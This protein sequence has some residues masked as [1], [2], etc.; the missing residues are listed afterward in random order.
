VG[1]SNFGEIDEAM[2]GIRA[3]TALLLATLALVAPAAAQTL[4]SGAIT[5]VTPL[6]AGTTADIL[7]RLYGERLSRRLDRQVIVSN[8]PGALGLLAAQ[9][10]A[11]APADGATLLLANSG[12]AILGAL[13][14]NLPFDPVRDFAG[15][16][17]IGE[18]AAVIA[19]PPSL[20]LRSLAQFV[21]LARAKPGALNYGSAG[22]G[23]ATHL[24]GA[25]FARQAGV[26]LVHVPYKTVAALIA[27][28]VEARIQVTFAPTAFLLPMLEEGRL[29]ALAVASR[30][31]M[32]GP[33][34]AETAL[35][36]GIDYEFSTWYGFLAP[37]KTPPPVLQILHR[38]IVDI[39][40]DRELRAKILAQGIAPQSV[41]LSDFD[42]HIRRETERLGPL[43]KSIGAELGTR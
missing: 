40:A 27:D 33:V 3:V 41:G 6:A 2:K 5:L 15:I 1:V 26:D 18:T 38:T 10:V 16:T 24:A 36:A 37:A 12:H 28:L 9:A 22:I 8:R 30:E 14:R 19:V 23:T 17:L 13:N 34:M 42:A 43:V 35:A 29:I 4:P 31:P 25:Y 32:R 7:A 11:L 20:G 21:N 39:G